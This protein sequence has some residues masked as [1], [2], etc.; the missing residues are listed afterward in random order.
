MADAAAD[1]ALEE[2]QTR[3]L[4]FTQQLESIHELLES[5]PQNA[6][7]LGIARDLVEVIRLTKEM[8]RQQQQ[9]LAV[10]R[11]LLH[12]SKLASAEHL[13]D[14]LSVCVCMYVRMMLLLLTM[15]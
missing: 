6:E 15:L 5:D 14:A 1:V 7:F 10:F 8:V 12:D 13:P 11:G 3:L 2:L 9:Y 4:T